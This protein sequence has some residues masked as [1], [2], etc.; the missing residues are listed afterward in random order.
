MFKKLYEFLTDTSGATA[1]EYGM[2]LGTVS[3][4]VMSGA[5]MIGEDMTTM[6]ETFSSYVSAEFVD[7]SGGGAGGGGGGA[8]GSGAGGGGAL[9]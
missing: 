6:F 7:G 1:I 2:I 5:F 8:G 9:E 4:V 3:I